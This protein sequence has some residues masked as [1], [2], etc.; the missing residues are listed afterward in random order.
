VTSRSRVD[1]PGRN[2]DPIDGAADTALEDVA[3][4]QVSAGLPGIGTVRVRRTRAVSDDENGPYARQPRNDVVDNALGEVTLIGIA[5]HIPERQ[6]GNGRVCRQR[7]C[8]RLTSRGKGRNLEGVTQAILE[9]LDVEIPVET[10]EARPVRRDDLREKREIV[11]RG[12][13]DAD[14]QRLTTDL[15]MPTT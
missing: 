14:A 7:K 11:V 12:Y 9:D 15:S 3:H 13:L 10:T 6:H 1:E 8:Q 4:A 2:P 5:A